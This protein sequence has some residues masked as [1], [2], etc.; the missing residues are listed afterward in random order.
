MQ[1]IKD[2]KIIEDDWSHLADDVAIHSGNITISLSRWKKTPLLLS[3]H[4]QKIGIR[5][6]PADPI[7]DIENMRDDLTKL[8]LIGLEFPVFTDGRLF[9]YAQLLRSHYHFEGE[10][11]A[12]GHY[13]PDQVFYLSRVGVNAFQLPNTA[14]LKLA[15]STMDDFTL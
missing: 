3:H 2:K 8:S 10:I 9:S 4:L 15:L 5:L 14:T 7:E 13:M 12:M 6:S 11:R 1:I